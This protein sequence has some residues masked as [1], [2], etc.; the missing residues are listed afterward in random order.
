MHLHGDGNSVGD[1]T[2]NIQTAVP[3]L[4]CMKCLNIQNRRF[5]VWLAWRTSTHGLDNNS[6]WEEI[7]EKKETESLW[8]SPWLSCG[9]SLSLHFYWEIAYLHCKL[10][11]LCTMVWIVNYSIFIFMP[12]FVSQTGVSCWHKYFH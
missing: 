5:V 8:N 2:T 10:I 3:S 1:M 6:H 11:R 12:K 7:V 9:P 4:H